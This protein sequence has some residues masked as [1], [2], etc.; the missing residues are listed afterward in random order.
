MLEEIAFFAESSRVLSS[1]HKFRNFLRVFTS[2]MPVSLRSG[3]FAIFVT[4]P[5]SR[6]KNRRVG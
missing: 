4:D 2:K 5:L 6:G 1:D 3:D